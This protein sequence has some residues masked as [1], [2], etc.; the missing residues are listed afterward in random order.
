MSFEAT[1]YRILIASPSDVVAERKAIPD[2]IFSWNAVNSAEYGVV[3]LPVM[4]ETH[5]SPELGDRPQAIINKQIV[6][7]CDIL[8]GTFWTRIG[9][10]TGVAESGTVEEI[11]EFK[12]SG[13]PIMLYFSSAPVVLDSVDPEQY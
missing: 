10:H 9:T 8:V 13:R 11:E 7:E 2:V 3:L 6:K 5:S 1:V 4:W 12:A